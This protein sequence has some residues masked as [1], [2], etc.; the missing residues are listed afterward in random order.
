[1]AVT[2]VEQNYTE[3]EACDNSSDWTG[4]NP[5]D[6][7]DFY[8]YGS[9][10]VGFELWSSGNND[11]YVS[12]SFDLSG[13]VHLR[14]W[15]MMTVLNELDSDA[16]GGIQFYAYDGSNT[17]YWKVSGS[18]TYPGGWYNLVVDLSRAVDSGTKPSMSAV[19]RIGFRF[20]LTTGAKKTQSLWIDHVCLCD[21]LAVYG[22][23]GGGYFD[24]DDIFS[25]DDSTSVATGTIR[26]IS[27]TYYLTGELVFGDSAGTNGCKFQ[28]KSQ[29]VIFE[30]RPVNSALYGFDIVDNGTGTTEFILGDKVGSAGVQ[31]CAIRTQSDA[32]SAK[33]YVDG[34][35]DTDVDN[36]KLY[37]T[38]FFDGGLI[39]F[40]ADATNVEVVNCSF[41]SCLQVDPQDCDVSFCYFINTSDA[42]AALL[43]NESI[44]ITNCYFIGN[45]SGAGV[46]MPSA[47][48]TPYTYTNL[49]FSGNTYDVLNSSGSS[50]TIYKEGTA[51]PTSYEGSS[52]T[53]QASVTITI[54]VKDEDGVVVQNAQTAI[55]ATDD[56][57]EL[58]NEDTNA[59]GIATEP[60]VGS[61]PR[62][63][64]VWIRKASGGATK[65]KN[66]SSVQEIDSNGLTLSVTLLED[67]NN[68]ATT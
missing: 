32:Q 16:N 66:Y 61:T 39:Y 33:F 63:V 30:D 8:K 64:R 17:G 26:K 31:G 42:D 67:P 51:D 44:S 2:V 28:A 52:V 29:V 22:D 65:Y 12:G 23:D 56:D 24:F 54:T 58:M 35:T 18:D 60:Y 55:Y 48:G 20:V 27:G 34:K 1:M 40:A 53:F 25:A 15:V 7:T 6:V 38:T 57:S 41:E 21:G 62:E 13:T 43:W 3:L 11:T 37:G 68:N 9:Q 59:S 19:T 5:D 36:F 49:V 45:T 14:A 4:L 46:E 47:V 50:I 10:C